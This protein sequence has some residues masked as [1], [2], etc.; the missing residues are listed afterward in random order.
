MPK[1]LIS[2]V[3]EVLRPA[4]N[5]QLRL[6][7]G[8]MGKLRFF[9]YIGAHMPVLRNGPNPIIGQRAAG[10]P[11]VASS[12]KTITHG[13]A[14]PNRLRRNVAVGCSI[15]GEDIFLKSVNAF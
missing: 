11:T 8:S 12:D 7:F 1:R 2:D 9:S 13:S 6:E 15:N 10:S 4:L 3:Q 5:A 14:D